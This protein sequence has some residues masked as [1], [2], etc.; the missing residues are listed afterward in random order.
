ME[1]QRYLHGSL[2][3]II[4]M[5]FNKDEEEKESRKDKTKVTKTHSK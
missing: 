5:S 1:F 4:L 3:L 2:F